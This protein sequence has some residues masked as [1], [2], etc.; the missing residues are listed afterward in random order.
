[1]VENILNREDLLMERENQFP[2]PMYRS[3]ILEPHFQIMKSNLFDMLMSIHYAHALMMTEEGIINKEKGRKILEGLE[4]VEVIKDKLDY[5]PEYED[6]FF[7]IAGKLEE[8]IGEDLAG[9]LHIGRSRNDIDSTLFRM[10]LRDR[11]YQLMEG[12]CDLIEVTLH[13]ASQYKDQVIL[14]Y[15]H[16]QQAQPTT[17]GHYLLGVVTFLKAD[18]SRIQD[19]FK[20][21][22]KSAMGAA[23]FTGSPF[24]INRDRMAELLGF[25][26]Y[27][28][29]TY[30]AIGGAGYLLEGAS[31]LSILAANLSRFLY[32]LLLWSM[33]EFGYIRLAEGH[34]QVSSIMPQ[35]RNPV[36]L[37]HSRVICNSVLGDALTVQNVLTNTPYGDIVDKEDELQP[38]IWRSFDGAIQL[39]RILTAV[40]S[41]MEVSREN[42]EDKVNGSFAVIT[43]LT[44]LLV[45]KNLTS[46]RE[47][48][49]LV[50]KL[51]KKLQV[52]KKGLNNIGGEMFKT[53]AKESLGRKIEIN[54]GEIEKALDPAYF[55]QVRNLAGG[56]AP[57]STQQMVE[58]YFEELESEREKNRK[59]ANNLNY[60]ERL[61]KEIDRR[62]K[63]E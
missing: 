24:P 50:S 40:L 53:V 42:I 2:S 11:T 57:N 37:E 15:T 3:E 49:K 55:V 25:D 39:I 35:K 38:Y 31:T 30:E 21:L 34:V 33:Q 47:A 28:V 13:G 10:A 22:N 19:Y 12:I 58:E 7:L 18:L 52:E 62:M 32:D 46:L 44:D 43:G 60:E 54:D 56:P 45:L 20:R 4:E 8:F 6:L 63:G 23:A 1:M 41:A 14:G 48:Y 59:I 5:S 29:N 9:D 27:I 36:A 51:V 17:L 26:G 16:T 61:K